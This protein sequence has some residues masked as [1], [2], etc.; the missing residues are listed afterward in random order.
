MKTVLLYLES[1]LKK[2]DCIIVATS[3]GPDS[4][5]LLH[6]LCELKDK[7][8][9]KLI[10][11]HVN[12]KLRIESDEEA[13]FV[14]EIAKKNNLIYEY[15]EIKEYNDDNLENDA[16]IKRYQFFTNLV[17]KYQARILMTAHHGDDLIETIL[18]RLVRGSTLK[19][20]KKKKKELNYDNYMIVRPLIT[21]TK[22]EIQN[23]ME[24]NH[25]KYFV[26]Q[27]NFNHKYTR[28]R[29]RMQI[30]PFLKKEN[31]NVHYK[32][33]KFSE[34][35]ISANNY[36]EQ[37]LT[38]L[39]KTVEDE[40]GL[41]ITELKKIDPFL[42]KKLIELKLS[43]IYVDDLFLINDKHTNF[44][45]GLIKSNKSNNKVDLPNNYQAI[46][47][48]NY[49]KIVKINKE[50]DYEYILEDKVVL[51]NHMVIKKVKGK[52]GKSNNILRL[53]SKEITLPL[54]VRTRKNGDRMSVKNLGGS[55]K[56]KDIFIDEKIPLDKRGQIPVVTDSKNTVLWIPGVKKS[57]FDGENSQ[58]YDIILSY[59]EE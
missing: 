37:V 52:E 55:K 59:E 5:C 42:L 16:R 54:I 49:F 11:A 35:L 4:M 7:L 56:I 38:S 58:I 17:K 10:I 31:A 14:K 51:P 39:I 6:L 24:E 57:K 33:L 43:E 23:F 26:D 28:N 53:N 21:K 47:S 8:S 29:Y 9:L 48:Y 46:K 41:K 32:F 13:L 22:Q 1:L 50:Q 20:Y 40:N 36:I 44:I 34:E 12:H 15:M 30:L 19:G 2:E 3:G 45:I 25:L 18:M 27:S